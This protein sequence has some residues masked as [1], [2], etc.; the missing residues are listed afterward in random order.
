MATRSAPP[1]EH[2]EYPTS[3]GK[4]MAETYTHMT[5]MVDLIIALR[6]HFAQRGRRRV[7][8]G[9]NQFIYY[10]E[11]RPRDNVSP[12]V[13]VLFDTDTVDPDI[14]QTWV[15]GK[16][17]E[18]V[19]EITSP[20]TYREDRDA[21]RA[22]YARLGVQEY[23]I[24]DPEQRVRAWFS[25][26]MRRGAS[27][28]PVPIGADGGIVS[29]LL[30]V[31]LRPMAMSATPYRA[32]H[33]WLRVIDP[34]TGEMIA[35]TEEEHLRLQ[36]TMQAYLSAEERAAQ[37]EQ[38]ARREEKARLAAEERATRAEEMLRDLLARQGHPEGESL[39]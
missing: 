4:P 6:Y 7:L 8:A 32:A 17:P 35:W 19:F 30:G 36:E 38:R 21:K 12:D 26:Y 27:L 13:Y 15:E 37:A 23:Y 16:F 20:S 2:V 39:E 25:A 34:Q 11:G 24:Y 22:L 10:T 33:T 31:E 28:E 5:Q 14:L 29:P 1:D 18:V 3:D 9:G